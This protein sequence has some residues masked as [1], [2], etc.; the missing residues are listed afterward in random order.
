MVEDDEEEFGP[1]DWISDKRLKRERVDI[2]DFQKK[3]YL[4]MGQKIGKRLIF[5]VQVTLLLPK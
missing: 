3:G 5:P 4:G 1:G 2:G